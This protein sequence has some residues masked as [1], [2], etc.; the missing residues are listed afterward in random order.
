VLVVLAASAL[1][2][3]AVPVLAQPSIRPAAVLPAPEMPAAAGLESARVAG[4][5]KASRASRGAPTSVPAG[6]VASTGVFTVYAGVGMQ[7][8]TTT[9]RMPVAA[10]QPLM[11]DWNGDGVDSP[12]RYDRG[13]WF[14]TNAVVG[15]PAWQS[16][17]TWGGQ[18]GELPVVGL[19]DADRQPDIGVFKDGAWNWRLSS[20]NTTRTEAF[21]A[22]GD[23]P[24]VGDWDGDGDDDLG[25]VRQGTWMLQ[26]TGVKKPPRVS[27]GVD[28]SMNDGT[29]IAIVTMPF[30]LATDTPIVGD[31]NGD[32]TDTPG[33]V[34]A[35]TTWILSEGVNRIRKTATLTVPIQAGQVPLIASQGTDIGHCPTASPVAEAK[36]LKWARRVSPP[37]RLTGSTAKAGYAEI[38]VTVQ[39]GLRYAITNDRTLRLATRWSEPYFDALSVHKTTEESI[40]RSANSAQAAAI[41][42]TTSKWKKVQNISRAKLLAY[43]KWQ[44][45]SISCQHASITPGGWGLQWQ[46]AL[47]AAT[48]GQAGWMLWD[49]LS[50]QERAY[51]ASMVASEAD[52]VAARGPHYYRTRAGV[53]ISPGNSKADEVSW[54]LTAPALALAMMPGDKRAETWRRTIVEY[55]IAAFARPSDLTNNLVVNGVNISKN[56]PGTN[57]NEDGTITNH[58][59]V[60]PD[61]IQNVLHL[62]W[63]ASM[64]RS[65]KVPVPESLFLN[66]DIVYRALTVVKF[67]SPPYAAPGGIVYQPGG[68]IYY[69][70]G[71]KWGARRPATFTGVDS[72]A[73][74]YSAPDTQAAKFLAAHAR[75][76]RGMQQRWTDGRIYDKGDVEESY[77]LGREEYALSQTALAWWAGAVPSGPG[78]KLDRS[79][80]PGVNLKTRGPAG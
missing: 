34:R 11:A 25:V 65:A 12:G 5:T 29:K 63:A 55:S 41:M 27:K 51:I 79:N 46:S 78:L 22:A 32:G 17:G 15:S 62:W 3:Q 76:T 71:V 20:D 58:G 61:Y 21:G 68:Q 80:V 60:N 52:A 56:L 75:D 28:V 6:A 16:K 47:W 10:G 30:G 69:P 9:I 24:V 67:P 50:G 8:K 2:A 59:I 54:D 1:L 43:A 18:A 77:G 66:A 40:R 39:D 73:S 19:I 49:E 44:L 74:L 37:A 42:L 48:A 7:P 38:Q 4:V 33:V 57:A 45:R 70:Q 72:F 36:A 53:E 26:F 31:W 23:I 14:Y 13:R 35:A 64:L